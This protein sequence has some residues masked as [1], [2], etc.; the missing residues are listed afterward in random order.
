MLDAIQS[1]ADQ[2]IPPQLSL[3]LPATSDAVVP[4]G[5]KEIV[6]FPQGGNS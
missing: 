4:G 1:A 2:K 3:K 5:R 6:Y